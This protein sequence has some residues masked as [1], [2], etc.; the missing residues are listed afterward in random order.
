MNILNE[1]S[2]EKKYV[3]GEPTEV[4]SFDG[5]GAIFTNKPTAPASDFSMIISM[6][7]MNEFYINYGITPT[8]FGYNE[9]IRK[10]GG[11][12][13]G[14]RPVLNVNELINNGI[15][16]TE[17]TKEVYYGEF[18]QK[19]VDNAEVHSIL[20]ENYN[21]KTLWKTGRT[22]T[23]PSGDNT[24]NYPKLDEFE[25]N[26]KKYVRV[27]LQKMQNELNTKLIDVVEWVEVEPIKWEIQGKRAVTNNILISN[28][29]Y[30]VAHAY[31]E[32]FKKDIISNVTCRKDKLAEL[33]EER[34]KI[35]E[36]IKEQDVQEV[37]RK[38]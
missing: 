28:L 14:A 8:R 22:F 2:L 1:R 23:L 32:E 13:E 16:I 29:C 20:E 18:P 35:N 30:C 27:T 12:F 19:A 15:N 10:F 4:V 21:N 36:L 25:F 33:I 7:Y 38:L 37:T 17:N 11:K 5:Q 9:Q 34:D 3:I 26:G 24:C 31:M 6:K